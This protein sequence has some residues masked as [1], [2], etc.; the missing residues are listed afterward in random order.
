MDDPSL[1][2]QQAKNPLRPRFNPTS[3]G[4]TLL[5]A[6]LA[7]LYLS[8]IWSS[9]RDDISYSFFREQLD[10]SNIKEV[11]FLDKRDLSALDRALGQF[12]RVLRVAD[13]GGGVIDGPVQIRE[14]FAALHPG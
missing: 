3:V 12:R 6:A 2:P 8:Q 5:V 1:N 9:T 7:A 11:E 14:R 10:K 13:F 4:L